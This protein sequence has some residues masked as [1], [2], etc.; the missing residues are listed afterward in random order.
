MLCE[1][2]NLWSREIELG[3]A[4]QMTVR[5]Y[6][7]RL[8]VEQWGA[9]ARPA[10][11]ITIPHWLSR[12]GSHVCDLLHVTPFSFGHLQLMQH[13]NLPRDNRIPYLLAAS[14]KSWLTE[15]T[16]ER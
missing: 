2:H 5:E 12:I 8:R 16:Q 13:D 3:G 1:L 11:T 7:T 14:T 9:N 4:A 15:R 10:L 6:L